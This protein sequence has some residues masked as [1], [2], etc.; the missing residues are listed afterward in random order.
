MKCPSVLK[1]SEYLEG[2]CAPKA[3]ERLS[4]HIDSCDRCQQEITALEQTMRVLDNLPAPSVPDNLW[5][6][7]ALRIGSKRSLLPL[8]WVWRMAAGL[9]L[10][11][12]L[13]I[14]SLIAY[15][16][17]PLPQAS[18][19]A[20]AYVSQHQL[21]SARDPLFDRASFSV[22]LASYQRSRP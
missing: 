12:A 7:V 5:A 17:Q 3:H 4:R 10:A 15:R 22:M 16:P 13:L 20:T 6:G 19:F 8:T 21:L 11:T 9:S 2:L 1:L 14:G 18:A